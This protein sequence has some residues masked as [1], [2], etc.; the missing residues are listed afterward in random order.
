MDSCLYLVFLIF[1]FFVS[2]V[3][4]GEYVSVCYHC[5]HYCH[6][7]NFVIFNMLLYGIFIFVYETFGAIYP[8]RIRVFPSLSISVVCITMINSVF[9]LNLFLI[10]FCISANDR[11]LMVPT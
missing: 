9:F 6:C 5:Y 8:L 11:A 10:R 1:V 2:R 4:T 3:L 7:K